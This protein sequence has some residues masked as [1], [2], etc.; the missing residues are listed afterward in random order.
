MIEAMR[1]GYTVVVNG[2]SANGTQSTDTY[3]LSGLAQA[4]DRIGQACE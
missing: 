4:F 2:G 1:R 3:F